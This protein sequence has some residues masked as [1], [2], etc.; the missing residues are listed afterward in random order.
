[1]QFTHR[2]DDISDHMWSLLELHLLGQ[3]GSWGGVA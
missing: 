3:P 1:M 2:R